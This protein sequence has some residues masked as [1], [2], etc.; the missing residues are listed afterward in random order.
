[1]KKNVF[2]AAFAAGAM[3]VA[4]ACGSSSSDSSA[5][6]S[7]G[8]TL[9]IGLVSDTGGF[10]DRGFNSLSLK[11]LKLA[12]SDG[13]KFTSQARESKAD[14]DLVPNLQYFAQQKYDLIIAVGFA[15]AGPVAEVAAKYPDVDFAIVDVAGQG[16]PKLKSLKNVQGI[17]FKEQEGAYLAGVLV[18]GLRKAKFDKFDGAAV[19][20]VGGEKQPAVD[21]FIAGFQQGVLSQSPDAKLLNGY[22]QTFAD[23]NACKQL[24]NAQLDQGADVIF[25]VAGGCGLGALDAAKEA[26]KW[27][28]G[29]DADQAFLGDFILTSVVKKVDVVVATVIK[30]FVDGSFKGGTDTLYGLENDGVGIPV[31]SDKIPADVQAAV[32]KAQKGIADGSINIDL[33]LK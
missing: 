3:L 21:R 4:S 32:E 24:A 6:S 13:V 27:G 8:K 29:V 31:M 12:K 1:M 30:S 23:Q 33:S 18:G 22:S 10:N 5:A 16:D 14:A 11:G 15:Q 17:T 28:V 7:G 26:N 20:T 25:A 2:L 19:G 9:K